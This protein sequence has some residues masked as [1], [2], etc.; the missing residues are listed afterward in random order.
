[1][2]FGRRGWPS[3]RELSHGPNGV[4][5]ARSKRVADDPGESLSVCRRSETLEKDVVPVE[6]GRGEAV[7]LRRPY[8]AVRDELLPNAMAVHVAGHDHYGVPCRIGEHHVRL[9]APLRG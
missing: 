1:M 9:V 7:V 2:R 5:V 6:K 8:E 3:S 4:V